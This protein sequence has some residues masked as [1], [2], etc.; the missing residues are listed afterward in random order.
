[1]ICSLKLEML[2][3]SLVTFSLTSRENEQLLFGRGW[4]DPGDSLE[5]MSLNYNNKE[6]PLRLE[7]PK[8]LSFNSR[9]LFEHKPQRK[10]MLATGMVSSHA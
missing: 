10:F 2:Q 3:T 7:S 1:M 5:G 4:G 6:P 9:N 8:N